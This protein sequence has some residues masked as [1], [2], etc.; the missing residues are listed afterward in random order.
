[1]EPTTWDR[2]AQALDDA[3]FP[4]DK[5]ELV[6]HAER[7]GADAETVRMLRAL[8]VA[9][10]RNISEIRSSVPLD[11]GAEDDVSAAERAVQ[12]RSP[13]VKVAEYLRDR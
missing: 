3:D 8:P 12:T 10:Y 7:R 4:M 11:P 13:H 1:M 6:T 5:Q 2:I 9:R